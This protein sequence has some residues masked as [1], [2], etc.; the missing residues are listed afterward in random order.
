MDILPQTLNPSSS[1]E[2]S[3]QKLE[4]LSRELLNYQLFQLRD[5]AV[6]STAQIMKLFVDAALNGTSAEEISKRKEG[7]TADNALLHLR[8]KTTIE[9][10]CQMGRYFIS[11]YTLK[12]IQRKFP[13]LKCI[14]AIDFTPE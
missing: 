1:H 6:Y 14:I 9:G 13:T 11:R 8:D 3:K 12:L 4:K 5:N 7:T 2:K 10:I